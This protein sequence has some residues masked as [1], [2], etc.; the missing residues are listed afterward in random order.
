MGIDRRPRDFSCEVTGL[1]A[2]P[3]D[4][5]IS[6]LPEDGEV[7]ETLEMLPRRWVFARF[8][9]VVDDPEA[10]EATAFI[11]QEIAVVRSGQHPNVPRGAEE[12]AIGQLEAGKP[13]P[14]TSVYRM[15]EVILSPSVAEALLPQLGVDFSA[16]EAL[17]EDFG[18]EVDF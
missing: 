8:Y 12:Q 4:N 13:P 5:L 10:L 16:D 7:A 9:E 3:A 1:D 14:E 2:E 15:R 17:D 11:D 6:D 18:G